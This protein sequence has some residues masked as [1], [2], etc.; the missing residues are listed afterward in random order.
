MGCINLAL[1]TAQN[2]GLSGELV[3]RRVVGEREISREV[4][5]GWKV[6]LGEQNLGNEEL[7]GVTF[8]E[9]NSSHLKIDG[10]KSEDNFPFFSGWPIFGCYVSF[11]ECK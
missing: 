2:R 6:R 9:A 10:P 8:P 1:R 5:F 4:E 11:R 7:L 3:E